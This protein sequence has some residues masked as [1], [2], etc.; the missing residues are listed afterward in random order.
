MALSAGLPGFLLSASL[1][2]C[3]KEIERGG[4]ALRSVV[5]L[6]AISLLGLVSMDQS[7]RIFNRY[8]LSRILLALPDLNTVDDY[9]YV[10]YLRSFSIDAPMFHGRRRGFAAHLTGFF[11]LPGSTTSEFDGTPEQQIA[12]RFMRLGRVVAVGRPGESFPIPGAERFYLPKDWKGK[13]SDAMSKARVIL[14]VASVIGDEK[15]AEGTLWEFTEAVRLRQPYEVVLAVSGAPENYARFCS[16][17][18]AYF[19]MRAA[20]L[21]RQGIHLPALPRLPVHPPFDDPSK[22]RGG[23]LP[24]HGLISFDRKWQG[25][26]ILFDP[27]LEDRRTFQS[28]WRAT[29][30]YQIDPVLD[31]V[32]YRLSGWSMRNWYTRWARVAITGLAGPLLT[33]MLCYIQWEE[34]TASEKS[35]A[36]WLAFYASLVMTQLMLSYE[37]VLQHAVSVRIE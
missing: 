2:I 36:L 37:R 29:C 12:Y 8:F 31:Q 11:N 20:E 23:I 1:Q 21:L 26:F 18:S 35:V 30:R 3:V 6:C 32:E 5:A 19:T 16:A 27:T 24:I 22:L 17:A 4:S 33:A 7:V 10:L 25:V 14:I 15:S 28:R 9:T 34:W 13:V